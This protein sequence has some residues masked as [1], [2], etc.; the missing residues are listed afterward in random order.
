M[1]TSSLWREVPDWSLVLVD[2]AAFWRRDPGAARH[3]TVRNPPLDDP[4]QDDD[5]VDRA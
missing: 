3:V 2:H 4:S 1:L 5:E